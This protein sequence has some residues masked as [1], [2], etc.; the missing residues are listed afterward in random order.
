M[1]K[2][3]SKLI[4]DQKTKITA[5]KEE[6]R[7]KARAKAVEE[8]RKLE[9]RKREEADRKRQLRHEKHLKNGTT[10]TRNKAHKL[11]VTE[12]GKAFLPRG[13]TDDQLRDA[14]ADETTRNMLEIRG[15]K[16]PST[17]RRAHKVAEKIIRKLFKYDLDNDDRLPNVE[18][19]ITEYFD[20]HD[21]YDLIDLVLK[22]QDRVGRVLVSGGMIPKSKNFNEIMK[23]SHAG[24]SQNRCRST[25]GSGH[26]CQ[27]LW[28]M[29]RA[30]MRCCAAAG[31]MQGCS[32]R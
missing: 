1:G 12:V 13:M 3:I 30:A 20:D 22:H 15:R 17:L 28:G 27:L 16:V 10:I 19:I 25:T 5:K 7:E 14:L 11:R 29:R 26:W 21:P 24:R 8:K 32:M 2:K 9:E 31:R 4:E 23:S 18:T 6:K